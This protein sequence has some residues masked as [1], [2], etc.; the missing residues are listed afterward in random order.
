MAGMIDKDREKEAYQDI[1]KWC[2]KVKESRE[3]L[4]YQQKRDFLRMLGVVVVIENKKPYY[5]NMVYHVEIAL[6]EIQELISPT[7]AVNCGTSSPEDIAVTEQLVAA[8]GHLDIEL[9][10]HLVIGNHRFVSLKERLRW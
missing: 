5:E 2:K 9:V 3:E 6:P 7:M 10:D 8:G 1:L 4:T